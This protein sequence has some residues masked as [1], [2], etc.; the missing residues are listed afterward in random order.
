MGKKEDNFIILLDANRIF[1]SDEIV[2]LQGDLDPAVLC[3]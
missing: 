1:S 2:L 3:A